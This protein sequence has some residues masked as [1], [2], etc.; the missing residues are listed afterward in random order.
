MTQF[1][2]N[3]GKPNTDTAEK[4]IACAWA[5][6]PIQVTPPA[7]VAPVVRRALTN[8]ESM[9]LAQRFFD[10]MCGAMGNG[11]GDGYI[12]REEHDVFIHMPRCRG[13]EAMGTERDSSCDC[14]AVTLRVAGREVV[15]VKDV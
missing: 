2:R 14:R 9:R 13:Y 10:A 5:L 6:R 4:C 8:D 15:E 3:C 12:E 11:D 7:D 1:C